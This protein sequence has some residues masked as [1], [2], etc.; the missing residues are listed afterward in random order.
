MYF[1]GPQSCNL[2][3]ASLGWNSEVCIFNKCPW[4]TCVICFKHVICQQHVM[5][6]LKITLKFPFIHTYMLEVI[7]VSHYNPA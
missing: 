3:S 1:L 5:G 4:S 6:I 7:S 2:D